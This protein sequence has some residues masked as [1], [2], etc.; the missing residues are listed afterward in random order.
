[1]RGGR[2]DSPPRSLFPSPRRARGDK[3]IDNAGL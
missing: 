3:A 2:G 1:M